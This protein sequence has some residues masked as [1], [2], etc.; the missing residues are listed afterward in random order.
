MNA[1][2]ERKTETVQ[3]TPAAA[4]DDQKTPTFHVI[5]L[6]AGFVAAGL[7]CKMLPWSALSFLD[8]G[9]HIRTVASVL[10]AVL[11]IVAITHFCIVRFPGLAPSD[12]LLSSVS[13]SKISVVLLAVIGGLLMQGATIG[14]SLLMGQR[15]TWHGNQTDTVSFFGLGFVVTSLNAAWE[16]YLFRGW[17]FLALVKRFGD[18]RT[19]IVLAVL[20]AAVHLLN[21][22]ATPSMLASAGLAALLLSYSM[23]VFRS[24]LVPIGIHFGWNFTDSFVT[25]KRLWIEPFVSITAVEL[26]VVSVAA[27]G[28]FSLYSWQKS[29]Q[30]ETQST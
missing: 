6:S 30:H 1:R 29:R 20:F 4:I 2:Y 9:S 3:M 28:M 8:E 16:E 12:P 10:C 26:T 27:V 17:S 18:H 11:G 13:R 23:L 25:A 5:G 22:K 14:I 7:A 15:A 21:P 24:I 19:S